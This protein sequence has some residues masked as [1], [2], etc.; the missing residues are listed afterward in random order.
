[1]GMRVCALGFG[2]ASKDY[3][4]TSLTRDCPPPRTTMGA[5]V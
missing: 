3:G 4:G 2:A 1:M 5:W